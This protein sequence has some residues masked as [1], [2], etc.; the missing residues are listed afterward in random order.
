[1]EKILKEN[2]FFKSSDLSL[3]ATL[4]LYGYQIEAMDRNNSDKVVFLIKR[5]KE[6][7]KFIQ[8]YWSRSLQVEPLA[9]FE[10][11]KNIKARIYQQ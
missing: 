1:M 8:A 7:D 2:D 5:N 11:L 3:I 4:Q 6:L 9:Y 10:S